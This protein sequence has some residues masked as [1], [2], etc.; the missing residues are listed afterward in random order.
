MKYPL[1]LVTVLMLVS[2]IVNAKNKQVHGEVKL[3][4][5]GQEPNTVWILDD[6]FIPTYP[7]YLAISSTEGC[8]VL[9]FEVSSEGETQNINVLESATNKNI[10]KYAKKMLKKFKWKSSIEHMQSIEQRTLRIDF[11]LAETYKQVSEKCN[12]RIELPCI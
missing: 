4:N 7:K 10:S 9:A 5:V 6:K 3:T 2:G 12:K 8:A 1:M 11:C